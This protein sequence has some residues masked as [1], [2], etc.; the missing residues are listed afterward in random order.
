ML[1]VSRPVFFATDT[2]K[3]LLHNYN[4]FIKIVYP[5]SNQPQI[6]NMKLLHLSWLP[7][8]LLV[9]HSY[10][11]QTSKI[12]L[13]AANPN[14]SG[15][16]FL[17]FIYNNGVI[18]GTYSEDDNPNAVYSIKAAVVDKKVKGKMTDASGL[19]SFKFTCQAITEGGMYFSLDDPL[20]RAVMPDL[21]F[22]EIPGSSTQEPSS[23]SG[24][25]NSPGF[26][27][28]IIGRWTSTS[29][30]SSGDFWSTTSETMVITAQQELM[31]YDKVVSA[32]TG[33]SYAKS[34]PGKLIVTSRLITRNG[35][36]YVINPQTKQEIFVAKY[37]IKGQSL[38]TISPDGEK[39]LWNK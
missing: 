16:I 28:R 39:Q 2:T 1:H 33:D 17:E 37:T 3:V 13:Q 25:G 23:L 9:V 4:L 36:L 31:I 22:K 38:L 7:C 11:Q 10:A 15:T 18:T 14:T 6:I 34:A 5:F 20:L 30:T 24:A 27:N 8:L 26:D 29:R 32:N 21:V 19:L 35:N 12:R